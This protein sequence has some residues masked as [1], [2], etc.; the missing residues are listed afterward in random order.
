MQT[1][2]YVLYT[3]TRCEIKVSLSLTKNKIENYCPLN[4]RRP[5]SFIRTKL[6]KEPLFQSY[7]F[8]RLSENDILAKYKK[9]NHVLSV[10]YYGRKPATIS[11]NEISAIK[12]FTNNHREIKLEK[13]EVYSKCEENI[14]DSNP[15]TMNGKVWVI[16]NRIT[17]LNLP[18]LGFSMIAGTEQVVFVNEEISFINKELMVQ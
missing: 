2:W 5:A 12:E 14:Q 15:Y 6:K 18:S 7:V 4:C 11:E 17:K 16:K 10:L 3:K 13:C 1:N 8:V 9:M